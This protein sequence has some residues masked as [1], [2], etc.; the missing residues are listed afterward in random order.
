MVAYHYTVR[1]M[2]FS[3]VLAV[4]IAPD[5]GSGS[6]EGGEYT[7]ASRS[8]PIVKYLFKNGVYVHLLGNV[9]YIMVLLVLLA[10]YLFDTLNKPYLFPRNRHC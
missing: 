3:M 1:S 5:D 7:A 4:M 6:E 8:A 10:N 9:V 2:S